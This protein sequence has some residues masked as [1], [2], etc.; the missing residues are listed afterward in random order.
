MAFHL[1]LWPARSQA[2]LLQQKADNPRMFRRGMQQQ[3]LEDGESMFARGIEKFL[4]Y[5]VTTD[6]LVGQGAPRY[7]G[8]D[9]AGERRLGNA[10]SVAA[11]GGAID[12]LIPP[13]D[14]VGPGR[15]QRERLRVVVGVER[16]ANR[17][18]VAGTSPYLYTAQ[19]LAGEH[20]RHRFETLMLESN[21]TQGAISALTQTLDATLPFDHVVTGAKKHSEDEGLP[22]LAVEMERGLW[23]IA[24]DDAYGTGS[25]LKDHDPLCACAWCALIGDVVAYPDPTRGEYDSLMSLLFCWTAIRRGV[26]LELP[27]AMPEMIAPD[28]GYGDGAA[29]NYFSAVA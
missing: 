6:Q 2:W 10:L 18:T 8:F 13:M 23:V 22:G 19:R 25:P 15:V 12:V 11:L 21:A 26:P 29:R 1:P 3:P 27:T 20:A 28:A 4:R 17:V 16:W 5:G 14:G 9:P 24:M 7:G